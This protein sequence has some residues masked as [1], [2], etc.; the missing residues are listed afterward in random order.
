MAPRIRVRQGDLTTFEGDAV[1][2]AANT[3][4]ALEKGVAGAI[5]QAGGAVIQ[6]ECDRLAPIDMGQGVVTGGGKLTA[7]LVIHVAII[8]DEPTTVDTIR[9]A[10]ASALRL[11]AEHGAA[12]IAMPVLGS[13]IGRI[14]FDEAAGAMLAV[15]LESPDAD[16]L[17]VIVL[18][19]YKDD[20][21]DRLESLVG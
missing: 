9:S 5:R 7:R 3:R 21:A 11:A 12:R 16:H 18:Y 20:H 6:Q 2:N 1:V 19:G 13:G 15:I 4:L 8:G 10:T 14:P 17:D